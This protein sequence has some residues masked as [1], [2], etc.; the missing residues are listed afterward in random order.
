[1]RVEICQGL[2]DRLRPEAAALYWE[3]FGDK[4]GRV[5]GPRAK[6]VRFLEKVLRSDHT[7][8][9]LS[10]Q[11]ALLG[12]VGFKS[13]NGSFAGGELA[14]LRAVYG[15]FGALWRSALLS[16]L[17]RDI[18]NQRFLVDGICVAAAARGQ[19]V[20]SLLLASIC[21]EARLR[22]YPAV[23]LDVV[24]TNLRARA[25]YE[26]FGFVALSSEDIGLLRHVFNFDRSTTMVKTL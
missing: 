25:L 13:V 18:E 15:F 3:A 26:R 12:M 1:M 23:R 7:F 6:A 21:E 22:N 19:G 24:D 14:D 10:E 17:K 9:A 8:V 16:L 5:M 4:L 2:P 20:G 11:G